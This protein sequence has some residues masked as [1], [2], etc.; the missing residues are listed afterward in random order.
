MLTFNIMAA[1]AAALIAASAAAS[2]DKPEQPK[3]RKVCRTYEEPGRITPKRVCRIV[4]RDETA[5]DDR[6]SPRSESG[7][8]ERD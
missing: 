2:D 8:T 4:P 5:Q 7:K 1:S 6:R 3:V